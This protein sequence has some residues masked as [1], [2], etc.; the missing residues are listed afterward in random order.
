MRCDTLILGFDTSAAHCAAALV[1]GDQVLAHLCE[2]M[3]RG[4]AERLVPLLEE[5]LAQGGASWA[6]LGGLGVGTGPGNFTGIRISVAAAR[7]LALGLGVPAIG[8]SLF[9]ARAYG[10]PRPVHVVEDAR[11]GMVYAQRFGQSPDGPVLW[12]SSEIGV[13]AG[14]SVVGSAAEFVAGLSGG[15]ILSPAVPVAVAIA[16]I[17]ARRLDQPQ[18]RPAPLYLR[19]ADAAPASDLPPRLLS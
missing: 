8:V 14:A 2:D 19:A 4:Q 17:A 11:R 18:S 10:L 16:L 7:G 13:D 12:D 9:E 6:D 1:C 5:V 15:T 3:A